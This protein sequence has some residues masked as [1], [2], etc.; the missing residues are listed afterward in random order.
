[1]APTVF[2]FGFA[3]VNKM[4]G[5][6]IGRLPHLSLNSRALEIGFGVL[7]FSTLFKFVCI[8][9]STTVLPFPLFA[10]GGYVLKAL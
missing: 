4:F 6:I 9:A 7:L 1:M 5:T 2:V 10:H 8:R 3:F